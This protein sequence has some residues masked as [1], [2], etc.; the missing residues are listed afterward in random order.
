MIAKICSFIEV[1][2]SM[3]TWAVWNRNKVV[4]ILL[5]VSII[6]SAVAECILLNNFV[7]ELE[8]AFASLLY[9]TLFDHLF[10]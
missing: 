3:R 7:Q 4:G 10:I 9:E 6:A 5:A 1:I 2:L 8:C